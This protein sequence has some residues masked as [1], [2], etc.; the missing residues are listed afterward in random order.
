MYSRYKFKKSLYICFKKPSSFKK[1]DIHQQNF[2]L[3]KFVYY[4]YTQVFS[5]FC[6]HLFTR[7]KWAIIHLGLRKLRRNGYFLGNHLFT[8]PKWAI[9]LGL[10]QLRRNGY[11]LGVE[12]FAIMCSHDQWVEHL[13]FPN[14]F[15]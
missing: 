14:N 10:G 11:F 4:I 12:D 15:S 1:L 9:H 5:N 13:G 6:N 7:L 2:V 8:R 3:T